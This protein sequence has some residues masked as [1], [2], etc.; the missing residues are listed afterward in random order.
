MLVDLVQVVIAMLTVGVM[1]A[2]VA[3]GVTLIYSATGIINFAQGEFVMLSGM[4]MVML[5]GQQGWSLPLAIAVALAVVL[6]YGAVLM[7]VTTRFG[8]SASLISVLIIT[9]GASIATSGVAARIWGSDTHRFPPFSGDAP[10]EVLG[11]TVTPQ[12]LW[13]VGVG[14]LAIAAVEWFMRRTLSG[15]AMRACAIDRQAAMMMGIPVRTTVLLSF[16]LGGLLGGIGGIVATPLTTIDI[17]SGMLLAIKGFS[18][19]MLGG[20]GNVTGA[21]LG[22]LLIALLESAAVTFGSSALKEMSTF[23][24]IILVLLFLPRGLLGRRQETALH[25]EDHITH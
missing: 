19:A 7:L 1:Y 4:T 23:T 14:A 21:L 2:L 17:N 25:H 8:R 20:M 3:V 24:I 18:A 5:Y 22:A 9:I 13:I 15:R 12:A 11:A 10:I 16:L 6:V